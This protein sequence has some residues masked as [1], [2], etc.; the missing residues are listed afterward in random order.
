MRD[1]RPIFFICFAFSICFYKHRSSTQ[2]IPQKLL[3]WSIPRRWRFWTRLSWRWAEPISPVFKTQSPKFGLETIALIPHSFPYTATIATTGAN[4]LRI[5]SQFATANS[6]FTIGDTEASS[7]TSGKAAEK[8]SRLSFWFTH[9]HLLTRSRNP[10]SSEC[11]RS[12][13]TLRGS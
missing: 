5:D 9:N 10:G 3:P 1:F 12:T 11:G 6:T 7:E 8:V 4:L 2:P 13:N